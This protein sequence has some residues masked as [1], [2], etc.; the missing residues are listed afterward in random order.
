MWGKYSGK[1]RD[2]EIAKMKRE[3]ANIGTT[4]LTNK[5]QSLCWG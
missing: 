5:Q 1:L 3:E 2:E 4:A